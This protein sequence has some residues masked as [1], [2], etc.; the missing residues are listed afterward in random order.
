METLV[1]DKV[2]ESVLERINTEE[3]LIM[4]TADHDHSFTITGY[5]S[6]DE[7]ISGELFITKNISVLHII[8]N[9]LQRY[10][11]GQSRL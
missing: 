1:L 4:V 11:N 7:P 9:F 2:V 8:Q 3:T 10:R 5:P 6:R